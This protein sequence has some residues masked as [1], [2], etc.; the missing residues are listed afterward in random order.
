ALQAKKHVIAFEPLVRNCRCLLK[1]ITANGWVDDT[2]VFPLALAAKPGVAQLYGAGTGASLISGWNYASNHSAVPISSMDIVFGKR[3]NGER[4]LVLVDVEGAEYQLLQGAKV[5]LASRPKPVWMVE[6]TLD[7]NRPAAR[8]PYF[9][10]TF[11]LFR[12]FDYETYGINAETGKM[13][14]LSGEQIEMLFA[15]NDK[16]FIRSFVF[17]EKTA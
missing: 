12:N 11:K 13:E 8:N 5:L 9:L 7:E 6:I 15:S 2:E 3:L 4:V 17:M 10:E 14:K 1:N 16:T